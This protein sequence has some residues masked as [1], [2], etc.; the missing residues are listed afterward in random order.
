MHHDDDENKFDMQ[1][2]EANFNMQVGDGEKQLIG[3]YESDDE[4]KSELEQRISS[5]AVDAK[6]EKEASE[7]KEAAQEEQ[8]PEKE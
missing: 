6:E 7:A 2:I 4:M 5:R 3:L 8:E 1:E